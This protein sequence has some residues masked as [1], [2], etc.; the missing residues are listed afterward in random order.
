M[1]D[2]HVLETKRDLY[3]ARAVEV[4]EEQLEAAK[5]GEIAAVAVCVVHIDGCIS[6]HYNATD[7]GPALLGSAARL[8]NALCLDMARNG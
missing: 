5:R 6:T 4:L 1:G 8:A 3:I 7:Q 2:L